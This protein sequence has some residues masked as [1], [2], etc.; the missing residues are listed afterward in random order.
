[1]TVSISAAVGPTDVE[2]ARGLFREYA[3]ALGFDL[4]FQSFEKELAE[5]PGEYAVPRGR[6]L[7]AKDPTGTIGC[8]ALRPI[9]GSL[10]EMKRLYVRR[11][12]RG[13]GIGR[14][15]AERAIAEAKGEGYGAMRL[16]T[17]E[18][19]EAAI[20]LYRSLGFLEIPPYRFNPVQGA[21]FFELRL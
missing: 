9:S 6:L 20:G 11:D 5:L 13:R 15:L 17:I 16:D 8:V 21:R 14:K 7:L 19:M 12:W 1:V 10:C 18:N 3:A 2:S 4:S